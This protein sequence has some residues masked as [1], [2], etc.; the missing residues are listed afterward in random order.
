[1]M[2]Q[3]MFF[4]CLRLILRVVLSDGNRACGVNGQRYVRVAKFEGMEYLAGKCIGLVR[5]HRRK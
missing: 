2:H 4:R 1:V 3:C 5:I